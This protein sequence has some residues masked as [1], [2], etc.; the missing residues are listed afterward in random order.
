MASAYGIVHQYGEPQS[1][2]DTEFAAGVLQNRQNKYDT[3]QVKVEQTLGQLGLTTSMLVREEDKEYMY[4]KVSGL[5]NSIPSLKDTDYS[6]N[7][8]TREITSR[9]N[10]ALD[11]E[12]IK[13]LGESKKIRDYQAQVQA[14]QEENPEIYSD[15]NYMDGL[16]NSDYDS[17]MRNEKDSVGNLS[18]TPYVDVNRSMLERIKEAKE[19]IGEQELEFIDAEGKAVRKKTSNMTIS[20]WASYLPNLISP[21]MEAQMRVEARAQYSWDNEL[22]VQDAKKATQR[23]VA[24]FDKEID[25]IDTVLVTKSLNKPQ[26]DKLNKEKKRF[27]QLKQ[28]T[29]DNFDPNN[30]TAESVALPGLMNKLIYDNAALVGSDPSL[31]FINSKDYA[32]K[33]LSDAEKQEEIGIQSSSAM[34]ATQIPDISN[35]MFERRREDAMTELQGWTNRG[36]EYIRENHPDIDFDK[37]IEVY[38]GEGLTQKQAEVKVLNDIYKKEGK[39]DL[40]EEGANHIEKIRKENSIKRKA[41]DSFVSK[42]VWVNNAEKI[43]NSAKESGLFD[44]QKIIDQEG[45]EVTAREYFEA[46]NVESTEDFIKFIDTDAGKEFKSQV[47]ADFYLSELN[48]DFLDT[49]TKADKNT[50]RNFDRMVRSLGK[51]IEFEDF[52]I[53][54]ENGSRIREGADQDVK[55]LIKKR[56]KF[57]LINNTLTVIDTYGLKSAANRLRGDSNFYDDYSIRNVLGIDT[58][59]YKEGYNEALTKGLM[60][61]KTPRKITIGAAATAK[62]ENKPAIREMKALT[63][64]ILS[65]QGF[66]YDPKKTSNIFVDPANPDDIIIWQLDTYSKADYEN[67]KVDRVSSKNEVTIEKSQFMQIAPTLSSQIDMQDIEGGIEIMSSQNREEV[68]IAYPDGKDEELVGRYLN[69]FQNPQVTNMATNPTE[70]LRRRFPEMFAENTDVGETLTRAIENSE[71]FKVGLKTNEQGRTFAK[72]S[73]NTGTADNPEYELMSSVDL[74]DRDE[75]EIFSVFN[76]APQVYI[77]QA[78]ERIALDFRMN[79]YEISSESDKFSILYSTFV[80]NQEQ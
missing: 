6:S 65:E 73:L 75:K 13:Q 3:N 57:S 60:Q 4:N 26:K 74:T 29:L 12:V 15:M 77:T 42:D 79:N 35:E 54:T 44:R 47:Y 22:A 10:E 2:F 45:N 69:H 68:N 71:R 19:V 24:N 67:K 64:D 7:Q 46:N 28:K 76:S 36:K 51:N 14:I 48:Q 1:N 43:Y 55:N 11:G 72:V 52:Y 27:Q 40:V 61:V 62:D 38:K 21:E 23:S 59:D 5:I 41:H 30:I 70:V 39:L 32:T 56:R 34:L 25:K 31:T 80:Q 66:I 20:E 9:I 17:Y 8:S 58:K 18:Y 33:T 49:T 37:K 63:E 50:R 16:K 53:K 78:L